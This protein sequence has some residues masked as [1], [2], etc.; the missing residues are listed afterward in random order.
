MVLKRGMET[1]ASGGNGVRIGGLIH[2]LAHYDTW[3]MQQ[4]LAPV[5]FQDDDPATARCRRLIP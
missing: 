3:H 1:R 2:L 4:K 5:L